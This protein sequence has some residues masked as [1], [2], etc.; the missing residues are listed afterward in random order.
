[1]ASDKKIT[2]Y[3]RKVAP[4]N[5][6]RTVIDDLVRSGLG[7]MI[8]FESS[9]L[10]SQKVFEGG[11]K[12]NC[13][14]SPQKLFELCKMDGA[15]IVSSDLSKIMYANVLIT[16][17]NSISSSETGTRHKAAERCAKQAHTFV[18]AVSERR[19]KTTLFFD[20]SRYYLKSADEL[21]RDVTANL[22]VLEEQ[23]EAF[24]E[25]I[26]K[27]DILEISSMV[28]AIDVCRVIQK[29][30]LM[31]RISNAL[32]R[33]VLE[34]GS[35]GRIINM[36]FRELT[37]RFE[38]IES[39]IIRDYSVYPLKKTKTLLENLTF[40]ELLSLESISELILEK[41]LEDEVE[42]NGYRFLSRLELEHKDTSLLV[43]QFKNLSRILNLEE[44]ELEII[45]KDTSSKIKKEI[46]N[47]REQ[48]LSG[49]GV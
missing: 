29:S 24:N 8:V 21:V 3:L 7:A 31:I 22:Q 27:L 20:N 43:N 44:K 9:D 2:D 5:P 26:G 30:E 4:G 18:I 13:K 11:F 1:M 23:R 46:D 40:D 19:K 17:D 33:Q 10:Y 34:L 28:S 14:F 45:L 36:R 6:I 38:K 25:L 42:A 15:I 41:S 37:T 16:P 35:E 47:L 32:K 48:I 12:I 39:D 49:K